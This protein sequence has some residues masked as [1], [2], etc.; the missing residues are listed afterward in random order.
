MAGLF[1]HVETASQSSQPPEADASYPLVFSGPSNDPRKDPSGGS[2]ECD[3]DQFHDQ[4][5]ST[6]P[7]RWP[8]RS[9][10]P[11]PILLMSER[12]RDPHPWNHRNHR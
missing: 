3:H 11:S 7:S 1:S 5:L 12:N 4:L 10:R 8:D 6:G 9:L 2:E